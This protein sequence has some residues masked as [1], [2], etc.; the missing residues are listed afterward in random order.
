MNPKRFWQSTSQTF[1]SAWSSSDSRHMRPKNF[2]QVRELQERF[3][4]QDVPNLATKCCPKLPTFIYRTKP[5]QFHELC[6]LSSA[7]WEKGQTVPHA[8]PAPRIQL[9]PRCHP[10]SQSHVSA[11][12]FTVPNIRSLE[13]SRTRGIQCLS[14]LPQ[15]DGGDVIVAIDEKVHSASEHLWVSD[16]DPILSHQLSQNKRNC[17]HQPQQSRQPSTHTN[18]QT[19]QGMCAHNLRPSETAISVSPG[20]PQRLGRKCQALVTIGIPIFQ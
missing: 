4:Q 6:V 7:R 13:P 17:D 20:L 8:D 3:H 9:C 16:T 1:T 11:R 12:L 2:R 14:E 15:F 18:W 19:S 5:I 10:Q